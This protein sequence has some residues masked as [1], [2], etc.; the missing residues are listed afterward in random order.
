MQR[1]F[2]FRPREGEA[3][4]KRALTPRW[5]TAMLTWGRL[6]R[7][8][9][10]R[11]V[12]HAFM[13]LLAVLVYYVAPLQFPLDYNLSL[14]MPPTVA[15]ILGSRDASQPISGRGGGR[16]LPILTKEART[17]TIVPLPVSRQS[18]TNA[19]LFQAPVVHTTI[20][21]RL[22]RG[23]IT[24]V[25]Q[26]GDNVYKIADKFDLEPQTIMWANGSL[27]QNPD[28]LRPGQELIILPINGVYHTVVKGDTLQKIAKK[29]KADVN[30]IIECPYNNLDPEN[31]QI[32]PGQKLIIPGGIK[33]YVAREVTAYKG[34]IP[35]DAKRG[36]GIFGWPA[37][38]RITDRFGF[39]TLSGRWHGGLDIA[40]MKGT[41]VYAA[42]SGFVIFA[43]WSNQGYG[44]L[45]IIDHLNGYKTYYGHLEVMYVS[46]GQSVAKG[47]LIAAM[48]STG[49]STGPH[50][51]FEVRYKG[52]RKNP[53]LY[54]P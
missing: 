51:H 35:K 4:R 13:M 53:E 27:A 20:P 39:R 54:L 14:R 40:N 15:P 50:L 43:G 30:H 25:V 17:P 47:S 26:K 33:P 7:K 5:M 24:Y 21:K 32:E 16:E 48:G 52:V 28:L 11:Y 22:R 10:S 34:P 19:D 37:S 2:H 45:I 1:S 38:G 3:C 49:R 46:V 18:P 23:V 31:P 44:N 6:A 12:A 41:P 8:A 29:Y 36:T 42:D 9:G